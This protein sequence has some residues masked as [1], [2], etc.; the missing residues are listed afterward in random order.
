MRLNLKINYPISLIKTLLGFT[1]TFYIFWYYQ[2]NKSFKMN[3]TRN[4]KHSSLIEMLPPEI[5]EKIFKLLNHID[6]RHAKLMCK[7]W[8]EIID[9][10]NLV[11]KALGKIIQSLLVRKS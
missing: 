7:R 3:V 10:G 9:N 4:T 2:I 1:L 6:I 11:K 8:K 5:L